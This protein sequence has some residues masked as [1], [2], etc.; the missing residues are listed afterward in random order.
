MIIYIPNQEIGVIYKLRSEMEKVMNNFLFT[1]N[2]SAK[3]SI[4]ISSESESMNILNYKTVIRYYTEETSE[5]Q[6]KVYLMRVFKF[7]R[8]KYDD[9]YFEVGKPTLD[10][11]FL[12]MT[13]SKLNI[14]FKVFE[15]NIDES[16]WK[17]NNFEETGENIT[18]KDRISI[19]SMSGLSDGMIEKYVVENKMI[20]LQFMISFENDILFFIL[21]LNLHS[22]D[23]ISTMELTF[24][25]KLNN[26]RLYIYRDDY[27]VSTHIKQM[28]KYI[29][30]WGTNVIKFDK[31]IENIS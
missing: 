16:I 24:F 29:I 17:V 11:F 22:N 13:L 3:T 5:E 19:D 8:G 28:R 2:R 6:E 30:R 26:S 25:A 10:T 9:I 1:F 4:L 23:F 18:V 27:N 31:I 20:P 14:K 12:I 21:S 15:G 7:F